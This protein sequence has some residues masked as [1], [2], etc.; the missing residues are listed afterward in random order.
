MVLVLCKMLSV[1]SG[2]WTR[3]AV[4]ISYGDNHYT[5]GTSKLVYKSKD[6]AAD[7]VI[8]TTPPCNMAVANRTEKKI[9]RLL[10]FGAKWTMELLL[11][12]GQSGPWNNSNEKQREKFFRL[13]LSVAKW[14]MELLLLR[15]GAMWTMEILSYTGKSG[16]LNYNNE[17]N[18]GWFFRLLLS[19]GQSGPR[20]YYHTGQS[21]PWIYYHIRGQVDHGM[22]ATKRIGK[23]S[24][25][26]IIYLYYT[27]KSGPWDKS[28]EK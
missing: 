17:N 4:S 25:H 23:N 12:T 7:V 28:N 6:N 8:G 26:Y 20:N 5:T 24:L 13:L 10:L 1:S 19:S 27:G 14:T 22:I 16:L 11:Y 9:F 15:Y 18:R 3:V 21:G 2:I